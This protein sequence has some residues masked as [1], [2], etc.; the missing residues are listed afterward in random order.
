MI[1]NKWINKFYCKNTHKENIIIKSF[2]CNAMLDFRLKKGPKIDKK[3]SYSELLQGYK[4]C[5]IISKNCS[6]HQ[7]WQTQVDAEVIKSNIINRAFKQYK[8][9]T[10]STKTI[11]KY[12]EDQQIDKPHH[13]YK[14][15]GLDLLTDLAL[16][17]NSSSEYWILNHEN[18]N[19]G[20]KIPSDDFSTKDSLERFAPY[21][22]DEPVIVATGEHKMD[23]KYLD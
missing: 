22:T 1:W 11:D 9:E 12:F 5:E 18:S 10:E 16:K 3:F 17:E 6:P 21:N 7:A 15:T 20:N 8:A 14:W 19:C 13:D 4:A 2:K 23:L